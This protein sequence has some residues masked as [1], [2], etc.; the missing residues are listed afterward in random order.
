MARWERTI[1]IKASPA[2]VWAVLEDIARWPEWTPSVVSVE[3]G[4]Q[5]L[6]IGATAHVQPRGTPKSTWTITEWKPGQRFA[7]ATRV[8]GANTVADHIIEPAGNGQSQ[9]RLVV[10]VG[11]PVAALLKPIIGR[12]VIRNLADEAAGLKLRSEASD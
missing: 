4:G 9:V 11:G 6:A 7:W 10:E 8:R 12:S 3:T 1:E 5:P 2:R